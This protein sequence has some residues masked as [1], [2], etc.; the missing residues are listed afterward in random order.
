MI[1][2]SELVRVKAL[3][4][5]VD[6]VLSRS[7]MPMA[8]DGNP[9]RTV[10]VKDGY[11]LQLAVKSGLKICVITG[12]R[13]EQIR[14]RYESLG[15]DDVYISSSVKIH[16]YDD[17]LGRNGLSDSDVLAM[18]D[19]IPDYPILRRCAIPCCPADAV[20]EIK[21]ICR[22]VSYADG[23]CGCVRDVLERVMK[24]Q[25][26]WMSDEHAFGW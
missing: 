25:D 15:I 1:E 9:I 16:D 3:V 10:N 17:F 23:G 18:G 21:A 14:R 6:G 8:A 7:V 12:A 19:D 22:Y 20:P 24:A 26:K 4:F 5:D 2:D 11:A 13:P